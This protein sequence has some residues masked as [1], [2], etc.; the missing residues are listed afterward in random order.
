M[1]NDS[2]F[3][4]R[5]G[6]WLVVIPVLFILLFLTA[7]WKEI[8]LANGYVGNIIKLLA[9]VQIFYRWIDPNVRFFV[10]QKS[11]ALF[12]EE[13]RRAFIVLNGNCMFG[14]IVF[15]LMLGGMSQFV[16]PVRKS[17]ERWRA[18]K[19]LV[20]YL[21]RSHGPAIF[22]KGGKIVSD[23]KEK[24]L[25]LPGVALVDLSS[26]IALEKSL[27]VKGHFS[28]PYANDD[29]LDEEDKPQKDFLG[30]I[31]KVLPQVEIKAFGPGLV[32]TEMGQKIHGAVDLR[33]QVRA[34]PGVEAYT[35]DGIRVKS[36]IFTV[37]SL[38]E[39]PEI[40]Y[41]S[42][43]GEK[44]PENLRVVLL[45]KNDKAEEVV[46]NLFKLDAADAMEIYNN[47]ESGKLHFQIQGVEKE[48]KPS[49]QQYPF[50]EDRVIQALYYLPHTVG[51]QNAVE[52]SALP[53]MVAVEIYRNIIAQYSYDYMHKPNDPKEF[54]LKDIKGEF[55]FRVKSKGLMKYQLVSRRDGSPITKDSLWDKNALSFF[56]PTLFKNHQALRD[57]GIKLIAA[58][59]SELTP[60]EEISDGLM[61]N[62]KAHWEKEIHAKL[63]ERDLVSA[64]IRNHARI[65]AQEESSFVLSDVFKDDHFSEEALTVRVFQ[66]LEAAATDVG[67]AR[68]PQHDTIDMLG[69]LY[70][71]ML[72]DGKSP[73][74]NESSSPED[75][76]PGGGE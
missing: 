29:E 28:S 22:V 7:F 69:S 63:A 16:L 76:L 23:L 9:E 32:F 46:A 30:R 56:Q 55:A 74:K 59:F 12:T 3:Y 48:Q 67:E 57:R 27:P 6:F 21:L 72:G 40:I 50:Y 26:A 31:K 53:N 47:F 51:D 70:Q 24:K 18:F 19:R 39:E 25:K 4:K 62:W 60:P 36:N 13:I 14:L 44:A 68:L 66:A 35:R 15:V 73:S 34:V 10:S 33:K 71:W 2:P 5:A 58:G 38:S 37:F 11:A 61:D 8:T 43:I 42:F 75:D 54:P 1:M 20:R 52:W 65:Q 45:E 17:N 49:R 64:R 41:V